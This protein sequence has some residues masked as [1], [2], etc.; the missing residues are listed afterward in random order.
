MAVTRQGTPVG[1]AVEG[2]IFEV[3]DDERQREEETQTASFPATTVEVSRRQ[4]Q[5]DLFW[6]SRAEAAWANW[7]LRLRVWARTPAASSFSDAVGCESHRLLEMIKGVAPV[8]CFSERAAVRFCVHR[9][10]DARE[11]THVVGGRDFTLA[12]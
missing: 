9:H 1:F 4:P 2:W 10:W 6:L 12:L 5:R 7:H 3:R 8:G 11:Q